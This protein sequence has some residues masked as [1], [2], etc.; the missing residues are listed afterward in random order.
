M[1]A[2]SECLLKTEV[3]ALTRYLLNANCYVGDDYPFSSRYRHPNLI[4]LMGYCQS[5]PMLVYPRE[6]LYKNLHEW[7]CMLIYLIA[8]LYTHL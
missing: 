1:R 7:I 4:V 3:A 8:V 6:S 2:K 5:V